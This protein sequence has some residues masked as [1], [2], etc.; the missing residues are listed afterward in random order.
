MKTPDGVGEQGCFHNFWGTGA[1]NTSSPGILVLSRTMDLLHANRRALE[2]TNQSDMEATTSIHWVLP[3]P[4]REVC[5]EIQQ[6]F[7]SYTKT[8][9]W[10]PLEVKK[11]MSSPERWIQLR[12]FGLLD[13]NV[14][15]HS[16]IVI[17]LDEIGPA[18]KQRTQPSQIH[19]HRNPN[20]STV[21]KVVAA[22]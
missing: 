10:V 16:R 17:V 12:G 20:Q 6:A 5:A 7:D 8:G 22:Q 11:L 13:R 18:K 19:V 21:A 1:Q 9:R 2:V 14:I 3:R 15:D 4:V